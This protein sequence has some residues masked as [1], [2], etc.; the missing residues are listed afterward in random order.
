MDRL[1]ACSVLFQLLYIVFSKC[2]SMLLV[3]IYIQT[4]IIPKNAL[5]KEHFFNIIIY[6]IETLG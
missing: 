2:V 1:E 3:V 4:V 6:N 5:K